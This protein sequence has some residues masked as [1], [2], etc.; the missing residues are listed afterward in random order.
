MIGCVVVV[1]SW[2]VVVVGGGVVDVVAFT[3]PFGG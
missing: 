1:V 2:V 3:K